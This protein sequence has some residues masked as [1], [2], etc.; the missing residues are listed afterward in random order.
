MQSFTVTS[1]E[2]ELVA[3]MGEVSPRPAENIPF[4]IL[5]LGDWSGRANRHAFSPTAELRTLRPLLVDR[6]NLD[7]LIARLGVRLNI[8][9]TNDA[10]QSVAISFARLD[11]FHPDSL[12]ERLDIFES[13]RQ[14]RAKLENP[15]TFEE[16]ASEVR[17]WGATD[18]GESQTEEPQKLL[19]DQP[20][21]TAN[22]PE[23]DLLGQILAGGSPQTPASK[24]S[25][26]QEKTS[27]EIARLADA[28]V[29]PYLMADIETDQEEMIAAV[30]LQIAR[31]MSTILHHQDFHAAEAAWRALDFLV[32]R[33]DTG[34]DL[35]IYLLD[36]SFDEFNDDLASHDDIHTTA[37]YH[38]LVEQTVGTVGGIPWAVV[39]GNYVFDLAT[40]EHLLVERVSA[41]ARE[42]GTPFVAGAA[43]SLLGCESLAATPDPHD[44]KIEL[45]PEVERSWAQV[46]ALV[47]ASYIG[48]ALPRFLLRLPYGKE[49][50]PTEKFALEEI[51][52]SDDETRRHESYL[53]ANPAFAAV[54][55]L[56]KGFSQQGWDFRPGD[57]LEIESLPLHVYEVNGGSEIKPCAETLLTV[58]AA[59]RIIDRGLMPLLSMKDTDVV[60]LG[61]F[62]SIKGT[63]LRGR[64]NSA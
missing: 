59:Q 49:T 5:L 23:S 2:G 63:A 27:T 18:P 33:L 15:K 62:Q 28:A 56:G 55:L 30:D 1:S 14:L 12:F 6:D 51:S 7:Q 4:R 8:P 10:S 29:R 41:I 32:S 44:W 26:P 47:A 20:G 36:T 31:T 61:M 9:I 60:R 50:D 64:W 43:P 53:W 21:T 13:L 45:A 37:L 3:Q 24:L 58:R 34:T 17:G 52:E 54:Y 57:D 42:A 35:K 11:D 22:V 39:A 19:P 48:F 16:A 46:T 25:Q 40:T 38:M